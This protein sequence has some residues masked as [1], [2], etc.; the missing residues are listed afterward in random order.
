M[1]RL[2]G[3]RK[4]MRPSLTG[5]VAQDCYRHLLAT[6]HKELILVLAAPRLQLQRHL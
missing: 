6:I 2:V 3:H 1:K 5:K 4:I